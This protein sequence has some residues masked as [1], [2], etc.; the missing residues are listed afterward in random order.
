MNQNRVNGT[1]LLLVILL[2]I[3]VWL[4]DRVPP[5]SANPSTPL[6]RL[7]PDQVS[8]IGIRNR[9]GPTFSMQ[10]D[11]HGWRMT[12]P[13]AIAA[14]DTRIR[15]LL[16]IAAS[17]VRSQFKPEQT[18]LSEFGLAPPAALLYLDQLEIRIGGTDPI[19]N[20]R[21]I[22]IGDNLYLIKD[23][24]PH[25]LL[26]PAESYVSPYIL[27]QNKELDLIETPEWQLVRV[28]ESARV[29]RLT[30]AVAGISI[31]RLNEKV[32]EWK[33]AQALKVVKAP[34][35]TP[36]YR[37]QIRVTGSD[38]ALLFGILRQKQGTLLMREDLGLAY[39]LP[40]IGALLTAPALP[41]GE[42]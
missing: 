32:D 36:D 9:S 28:P 16:E 6:T 34:A 11:G 1:L 42:P 23:L 21:Y 18:D 39:D 13:Y 26:A 33:Y 41:A 27:P 10:R 4:S 31:D 22:G 30:P 19:N 15:R 40:R 14:S 25:L 38:A 24:F 8:V 20:Y 17:P 5:E 7:L 35:G 2:G 29:W 3:L 37:I 12:K